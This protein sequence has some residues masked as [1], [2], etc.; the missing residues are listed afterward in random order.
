[1]LSRHGMS[2]RIAYIPRGVAWAIAVAG[3]RLW[4]AVGATREPR[5]TRYVVQ[6]LADECTLDVSRARAL[7]GYS[8]RWTYRDAPLDPLRAA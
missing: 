5:L 8:P 3:E 1:M 7:L 4:S 6:N 2:A